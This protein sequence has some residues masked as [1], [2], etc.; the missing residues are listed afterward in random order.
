M[1]C[2]QGHAAANLVP[3]VASNRIGTERKSDSSAIT[4]Y[5]GSFV[6]GATG[7]I[8]AQAGTDR[9]EAVWVQAAVQKKLKAY[10][11]VQLVM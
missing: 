2:L 3:V 5:G 8:L 7:E 1:Y 6:A 4:F 11:E 9:I 10:Q